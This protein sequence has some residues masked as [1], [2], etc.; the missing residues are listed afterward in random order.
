VIFHAGLLDVRLAAWHDF[1]YATPPAP[2]C[3][4]IP[5]LGERSAEAIKAAHGAVEV[6][7]EIVRDLHAL[8]GQLVTE[9]RAD[10]DAR[11]ARGDAMLDARDGAR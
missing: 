3:R 9:I 1:G 5:P 2:Y 10:Q 7:D 8:R 4:T 6:I 11:A